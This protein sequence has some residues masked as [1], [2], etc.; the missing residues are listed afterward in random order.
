M[1]G[2]SD[3]SAIKTKENDPE[4]T[5]SC[6]GLFSSHYHSICVYFTFQLAGSFRHACNTSMSSSAM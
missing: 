5:E 2:Q 1:S 4:G 6:P 3:L